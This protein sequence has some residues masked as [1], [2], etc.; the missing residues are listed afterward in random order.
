MLTVLSPAKTLDFETPPATN[1]ATQPRM[2]ESSQQLVDRL[3][4][5]SA[6]QLSS[7]MG[8]SEKLGEL[9]RTRFKSW[10]PP[11]TKSNAK[12]A[13]LAFKGDVYRGLEAES[14]SAEDFRF[15]QKHVRILSGLYGVLRPLDL[16]Q[17][18]RLEMGTRLTNERGSNL[19]QYWGDDIS[20]ELNK[21]L[22]SSKSSTLVNLASAEYFKSVK[23]GLL[24]ADVV[25][26]TFLDYKNGKYKIISFYAKKARGMMTSWIVRNEI[27]DVEKLRKFSAAGYRFSAD[28]SGPGAPAFVRDGDRS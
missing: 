2:L 12:Q 26:P 13:V 7:L 16:I 11:F 20:K 6:G 24:E 5:L 23:V 21:Q 8:I 18:Y 9:N 25:V 14:F 19:Y 10:S 1:I 22:R 4:A 3:Q 17:P 27:S 28:H 15:A